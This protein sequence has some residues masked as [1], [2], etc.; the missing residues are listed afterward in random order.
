EARCPALD[1]R[2]P[3]KPACRS[4]R[5]TRGREPPGACPAEAVTIAPARPAEPGSGS[6][7]RR[8]TQGAFLP[9]GPFSA[10]PE[11]PVPA[12]FLPRVART[13]DAAL[14]G[15]GLWR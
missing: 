10:R 12:A 7:V 5:P 14:R 9:V 15:A 2:G 13:Q 8:A 6:P 11:S 3:G 1:Y 4:R